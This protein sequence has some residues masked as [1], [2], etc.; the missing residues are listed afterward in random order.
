MPTIRIST[1]SRTLT[2][3][4]YASPSARSDTGLS[5]IQLVERPR[6]LRARTRGIRLAVTIRGYGRRVGSHDDYHSPSFGRAFRRG[7]CVPRAHVREPPRGE[8]GGESL[9]C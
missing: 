7:G 6:M 4:G 3:C 2:E 1:G 5:E 9:G 8:A